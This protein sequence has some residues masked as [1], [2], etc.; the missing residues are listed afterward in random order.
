MIWLEFAIA[1]IAI[2]ISGYHLS[3]YGDMLA[4]KTG[5]GRTLIGVILL[6]TVTSL[7]ELATGLSAVTIAQTPDIAAGD[8]LGSCVFNLM[9]I[10]LIDL[11]YRPAPIL[12]RV[13]QGQILS[14]GFGV[15][16]IGIAAWGLV[17]GT[18]GFPFW[19]LWIGPATPL[20]LILYAV[21][22]KRVFRFERLRMASF[23]KEKAEVLNYGHVPIRTVY[24]NVALNAGVVMG[25]GIW[26][27]FIGHRMAEV[28]GW[29]DTFVGN[30]L[31][32]AATSLPE[33]VTSFAALR[34]AAPD[35]AVANLFGSNLF[36]MVIL[37]IDD[38]AY[39]PGALLGH[40][41]SNHLFSA[42][43]ALMMTGIGIAGLIYRSEKKAW[44]NLS[45]DGLALLAL[46]L[47]NAYGLFT[48]GIGS[49]GR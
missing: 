30:L 8:V 49:P 29:G 23:I 38:I 6:A 11:F 12:S 31:I 17:I 18:H 33:I 27:P 22:V 43:T 45:W 14:A 36:N 26:L 7:P 40:V 3:R 48:I 13:N 2:L 21:A 41:S 20:I 10:G 1:T 16:L 4:E 5:V 39:A 32:A 44:R 47:L 25:V 35:L 15:L 42:V 46:Y 19:A 9:L 28:T 24:R 34:L 37:A